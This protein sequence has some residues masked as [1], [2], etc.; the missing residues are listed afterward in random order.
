MINM[1]SIVSIINKKL[2]KKPKKE[3]PIVNSK[4]KSVEKKEIHDGIGTLGDRL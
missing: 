1:G 4:K 2:K 3:K